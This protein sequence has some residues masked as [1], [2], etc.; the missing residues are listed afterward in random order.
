MANRLQSRGRGAAGV[1]CVALGLGV[2]L[3]WPAAAE[4]AVPGPVER[5]AAAFAPRAAGE[6]LEA[7]VERVR[8]EA[9]RMGMYSA[10]PAAR[11]VLLAEGLG[12][13]AE[14]AAAAV[15]LAPGLPA[16][17]GALAAASPSL[18][19][20]P[21]LGRGL[22]EMERNL[23]ASVWWRATALR[24]L[25]CALLAG[26]LLFLVLSALRLA[27]VAA[28]DLSHRLPGRLPPAALGS[29]LAVIAVTPLLA[30]EGLVGLAFGA[31][32]V[33]LPWAAAR[34]RAALAASVVA[35]L[36]AVYPLT[37]ETGRWI[38]ALHADP[39]TVAIRNAE[40][41]EIGA[42]ERERLARRVERDDPAAAHALA[43][44][45]KRSDRLA[46]A[47]R[48]L[49][50][51]G[52]H[53]SGNPVLLN[54]AANVRF[55]AG[56][57]REAIQLYERASE[58]GREAAVLFNL[59]QVYGSRIELRRQE[60]ALEAAHAISAGTVRELADLRGKGRLIVDL[61]WPASDLRR[62]L[63]AVA[64]GRAVAARLRAPFGQGRLAS[65]PVFAAGALAG[66]ALGLL[67]VGR[68]REASRACVLC[69]ARRCERCEAPPRGERCPSCGAPAADASPLR[70]LRAVARPALL[71]A[72][73]GLAGL[74]TGR[75]WF[76]WVAIVSAAGAVAA[77]A[78]RE[79]VVADPLAA[80]LAGQVAFVLAAAAAALLWAATTALA[81]RSPQ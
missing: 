52:A 67:L 8:S 77:F 4:P 48:W 53:D 51:A 9:S 29:L 13:D 73:P 2:A 25:T 24:V 32:C 61:S 41:S 21:A 38:E 7:R 33:S 79:G 78:L 65:D 59:A 60:N 11:G 39:D 3:A 72:V 31:L 30:G 36:A 57:V 66:L 28:H 14:R 49:S 12:D 1:V 17:W 58:R 69:G 42:A 74:E 5:L 6:P 63:L 10:E 81:L 64:D 27:P 68:G 34:H 54:D 20:I 16:A 55:A 56:D 43:L 62:R 15:R 46:E 44:L 26:G 50:L 18:A 80:G 40:V 76:A 22:L 23:D 70:V 47:E 45:S 35:V 75:P 37:D 19:T 71:R